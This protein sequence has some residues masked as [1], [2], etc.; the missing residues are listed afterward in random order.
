MRKL[1]LLALAINFGLSMNAQEAL[2]SNRPDGLVKVYDRS[3]KGIKLQQ[4]D[5]GSLEMTT[6]NLSEAT[7]FEVVFMADNKTVYVKNPIVA[8]P[9]TFADVTNRWVKGSIK[10]NK[11]TIP[12]KSLIFSTQTDKGENV[13]IY[14]GYYG[15]DNNQAVP[16]NPSVDITYTM[17]EDQITL[18]APKN[19]KTYVLSCIAADDS[20]FRMSEYTGAIYTLNKEKTANNINIINKENKLEVAEETFYDLSGRKCTKP[21]E[22]IAIKQTKFKN[23]TQKS[24]KFII[25]K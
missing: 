17:N 15:I 23:G 14:M 8:L 6:L 13:S 22:G 12:H 20:W 19:D 4:A 7:D 16:M 3:G 1:L 18:D 21:N 9:E 11:I 5:D 25:N 10:G 24:E 2:L